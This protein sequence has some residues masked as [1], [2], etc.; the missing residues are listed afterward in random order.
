M[1]YVTFTANYPTFLLKISGNIQLINEP[2]A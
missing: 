2:T 1:I